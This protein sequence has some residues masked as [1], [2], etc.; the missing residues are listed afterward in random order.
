VL[1][2]GG[3]RVAWLIYKHV[4][5]WYMPSPVELDLILDKLVSYKESRLG[6]DK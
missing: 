2:A 4:L 1:V 5:G 6:R 3:A